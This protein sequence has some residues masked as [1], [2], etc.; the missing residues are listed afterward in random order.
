[1]RASYRWA[2]ANLVPAETHMKTL[3]TGTKNCL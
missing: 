3:M 2:L 1:V